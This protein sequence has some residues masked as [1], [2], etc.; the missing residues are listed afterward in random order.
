MA[1]D[2]KTLFGHLFYED[3]ES[4]NNVPTDDSMQ[5]EV[6]DEEVASFEKAISDDTDVAETA[7]NIIEECQEEFNS[8]P[9]TNISHVQEVLDILG[10]NAETTVVQSV[11]AKLVKCDLIQLKED[12]VARKSA[13]ENAIEQ[14]RASGKFLQKN[15][16]EEE[17]SLKEAEKEAESTYSQSVAVANQEC[18]DAIEEERKRCELAIEEIRRKGEETINSA[19]ES[20]EITLADI[21]EQRKSNEECKKH[22]LALVA[23]TEKVGK[24]EIEKIDNWLKSLS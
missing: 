11:L 15:K 19:K 23:E 24:A 1:K 6:S 10:E 16:D 5:T 14:T 7:R 18:E 20:R 3:E 8:D 9:M 13:I 4:T 22:S 2:L 17:E 21:A 12:G